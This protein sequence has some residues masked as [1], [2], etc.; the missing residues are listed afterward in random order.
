[1][2][3]SIPLHLEFTR[4]RKVS[5]DPD[6]RQ[7]IRFMK[8]WKRN[9]SAD[10]RFKSFMIEL[11]VAHLNDKG[12]LPKGNYIEALLSVFDYIART[13]LKERIIFT[14]YYAAS[15]VKVST[16]PIQIF[17]PV[18][19]DNNVA[20]LYTEKERIAIVEAAR[21]AIDAINW[22]RRATTKAD[23]VSAWKDVLG[24]SFKVTT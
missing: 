3:T 6:Y 7:T 15:A 24:P 10:F 13:E 22:G 16:D 2:L 8:W 17:D 21:E 14:D 4:K 23:A 12:L 5:S 18:N 9:Q 19:P 20:S 11:I 1:V